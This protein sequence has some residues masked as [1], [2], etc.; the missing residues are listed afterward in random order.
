MSVKASL[1]FHNGQVLTLNDGMPTA[2]AVAVFGDRIAL[3][4]G[5][6]QVVDAIGPLTEVIDLRGCA[7]LPGFSDAHCHITHYGMSLAQIDCRP[8]VVRDLDQITTQV[9]E[10]AAKTPQDHW[11]R[12]RGYDD[13]RLPPKF[14]IDRYDLDRVSPRHPTCLTRVCGHVMVVNS[15]AL[16][17][18]GITSETPDPPGGQIDRDAN[19]EPTGVLRETALDLIH[20]AIPSPTIEEIEASIL[21][22]APG[23]LSAGITSIHNAGTEAPEFTAF[24]RLRDRGRLPLRAYLMV[25]PEALD[26]FIGT[27]L[28]TGFGD[29]W[30]R[31][32]ALKIMLDGGIGARTAAVGQGFLDQPDNRGILWMTQD[33]L[34]EL[35]QR[36][37]RAGL[38]IA[39]HA[40]GD[41]AIESALD[42][43]DRALRRQPRT[44]HR[45]R[46]EH[47]GLP[48]HGLKGRLATMGVVASVQPTFLREMGDSYFKSLGE[49]RGHQVLPLRSLIDFGVPLA[50][51]SDSPVSTFAPLKGIAAAASRRTQD[52]QI[53]G[54]G[55]E[56]SVEE[57]IRMYTKGGAFASFEERIKGSIEVGKLAD[58]VVLDRNPLETPVAEISSIMVVLTVLGGKI[59]YRN[60]QAST[61]ISRERGQL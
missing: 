46:I 8:G 59:V 36:A 47:C 22:A 17:L 55:Q 12:G 10:E 40:I 11:I 18:A 58:L 38:Q 60:E 43:Y 7:L 39:T 49:K 44:D 35:V 28:Y 54:P 50:G 16:A 19:G 15:R 32:G 14:A 25:Q 48:L 57:A 45:F 27:G 53:I 26:C 41:R 34:D 5:E 51:G 31:I 3:V 1:V 20:N 13:T 4:G 33:E 23:Y 61:L 52:G 42:A 24:Q 2:Q 6:S 29:E 56:I 37:A 9:R 21:R 30:L